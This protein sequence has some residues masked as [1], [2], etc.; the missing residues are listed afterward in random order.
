MIYTDASRQRRRPCGASLF[1]GRIWARNQ[2]L[3][4]G[5]RRAICSYSYGL[6]V[7][8]V[9]TKVRP[10]DDPNPIA[11]MIRVGHGSDQARLLGVYPFTIP[12]A[13]A[14]LTVLSLR[15]AA[16]DGLHGRDDAAQLF[17]AIW[18]D[19]TCARL[20][21]SF[22]YVRSNIAIT[23]PLPASRLMPLPRRLATNTFLQLHRLPH[24]RRWC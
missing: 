24:T 16:Q 7:A 17:R 2:G 14:K 20:C 13:G 9:F 10:T 8:W 19:P 21:N 22:A 18:A 1:S 6:C 15:D 11:A 12:A 4:S 5:P 23:N 3:Q